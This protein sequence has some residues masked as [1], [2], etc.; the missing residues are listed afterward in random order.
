V[1]PRT[2]YGVFLL[3]AEVSPVVPVAIGSDGGELV[4]DDGV[5]LIS[6]NSFFDWEEFAG[7]SSR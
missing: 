4:G 7:P 5:P 2:G 6:P 1:I 3:A